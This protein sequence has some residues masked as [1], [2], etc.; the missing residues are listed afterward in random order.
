MMITLDVFVHLEFVSSLS[1]KVDG[2][3][4]ILR[5]ILFWKPLRLDILMLL[6]VYIPNYIEA[7]REPL[8]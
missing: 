3:P 1:A 2:L 6:I 8:S 4:R 5:S 7:S